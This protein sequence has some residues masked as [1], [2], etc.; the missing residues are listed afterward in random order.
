MKISVRPA[1]RDGE[2]KVIFDHPL[3][4]KD[5][6]ISSE[7]ITLTFVA[8]DIYSPASKQRYTIQFSVDELAT[9]LDVDDDGGESADDAGDGAN[10]A[11]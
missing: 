8:R 10:A 2:A 3:E 1:K 7:D 5:I 6:S 4:R 11:E 9:I